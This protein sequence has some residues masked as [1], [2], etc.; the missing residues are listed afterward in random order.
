MV[1][2]HRTQLNTYP[3]TDRL[4]PDRKKSKKFPASPEP[5]GAGRRKRTAQLE[6]EYLRTISRFT[7]LDSNLILKGKPA[8]LAG[9]HKEAITGSA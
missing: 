5:I 1:S 4:L 2:R 3:G 7:I 8:W 6:L 9:F